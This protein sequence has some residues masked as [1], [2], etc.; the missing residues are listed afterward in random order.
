MFGRRVV[1]ALFTAFAAGAIAGCAA[2]APHDI[3]QAG[4]PTAHIVTAD[5]L[6][7]SID[8]HKMR[9]GLF[10][11]PTQF[12][13]APGRHEIGVSRHAFRPARSQYATVCMEAAAGRSYLV[14][15]LGQADGSWTTV[16]VDSA[17]NAP[18][19]TTCQPASGPI[20][21][22]DGV[23]VD[24]SDAATATALT[25]TP[26]TTATPP[27]D[28]HHRSQPGSGFI[29]LMGAA[30]GGDKITVNGA[31]LD[32]GVGWTSAIAGTVTPLWI[33]RRF[34]FGAG[35]EI[36]LKHSS[37][38]TMNGRTAFNRFPLLVTAHVLVRTERPWYVKLGGGIEKHL[39]GE[40]SS[41]SVQ[42]RAGPVG[43]IGVYRLFGPRGYGA[44]EAAVRYSRVRHG[45]ATIDGSSVGLLLS[46]HYNI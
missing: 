14:R 19:A 9:E 44:L 27:A 33:K 46:L 45:N 12:A 20:V 17:T 24:P 26:V 42:G 32:A 36:G 8:G 34:G 6:I 43:E 7:D 38:G 21:A 29:L 41:G 28:D 35:V 13:V 11:A 40:I 23:A 22:V 2:T 30:V 31:E 39:A 10:D 5:L 37:V 15:P 16:I 1:L 18:V 25:A 3:R 4:A